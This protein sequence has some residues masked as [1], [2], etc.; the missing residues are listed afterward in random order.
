MDDRLMIRVYKVGCGDCIF[1]RVPDTDRPYHILIDCG[2]FFG[3]RKALR[4]RYLLEEPADNFAVAFVGRN[5]P[6]GAKDT[7]AGLGLSIVLRVAQAH[8]GTVELR[9]AEGGGS[10]FTLR[11]PVTQG[12]AA[13]QQADAGR[14]S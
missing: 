3:E 1:V 10:V 11:L 5:A 13:E 6:A 12:K 14:P 4:V 9:N 8:G 7:G 2:N